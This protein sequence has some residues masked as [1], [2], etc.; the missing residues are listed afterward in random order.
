MPSLKSKLVTKF[1]SQLK[2]EVEHV[3]RSH[4]V[5]NTDDILNS[6]TPTLIDFVDY[7]V[8]FYF[9]GCD[10]KLRFD[11]RKVYKNDKLLHHTEML[12]DVLK[13]YYKQI[14]DAVGNSSFSPQPALT[15]ERYDYY[16]T[17][18]KPTMTLKNK[19][20]LQ[21]ALD[22]Y[23][24]PLGARKI[25]AA[26]AALLAR[27]KIL[28]NVNSMPELTFDDLL[29]KAHIRPYPK[30]LLDAYLDTETYLVAK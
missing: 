8:V 9:P 17:I 14:I 19:Y 27:F 12:S 18:L 20:I 22:N 23:E 29:V 3:I 21:Q 30:I 15:V 24:E 2:N 25:M 28:K 13:E 7:Y 26:T 11:D 10:T 1:V 5:V 6:T 16:G 4:P